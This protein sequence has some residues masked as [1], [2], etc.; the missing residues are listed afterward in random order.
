MTDTLL[1]DLDLAIEGHPAA[2]ADLLA[3]VADVRGQAPRMTPEFAAA[4]DERVLAGSAARHARAPLLSGA[5]A[6]AAHALQARPGGRRGG[7][8]DRRRDRDEW[9]AQVADR[10]VRAQD[11]YDQAQRRDHAAG[12][13]QRARARRGEDAG[14]VRR[15]PGGDPFGRAL[16][17]VGRGRP[18]VSSATPFTSTST[19]PAPGRRVERETD[20]S[21]LTTTDELQT[22]AAGSSRHPAGQRLRRELAGPDRRQRGHRRV[23]AADPQRPPRAGADRVH[24]AGQGD[25]DEPVLAATSPASSLDQHPLGA[26]SGPA[27]RAAK[28]PADA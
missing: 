24:P 9:R 25:V 17:A 7:G 26:P 13:R 4:L 16:I 28:A 3:L 12:Q 27:R 2:D 18:S 10:F 23:H 20:L 5:Q 15:Q 11:Q 8:G 22:V 14:P 19:A 21:L 6:A 1:E